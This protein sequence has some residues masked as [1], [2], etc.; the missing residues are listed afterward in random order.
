MRFLKTIK[1]KLIFFIVILVALPNLVITYVSYSNTKNS[2]NVSIEETLLSTKLAYEYAIEGLKSEGLNYAKFF[3]KDSSLKEA[4]SYTQMTD[5]NSPL[6]DILETYFKAL[7]LNNIE[8]TNKQGN[9]LARGHLPAKFGDSKL[10]FP[11][12]KQMLATQTINW[13]YQN[14]KNG[15]TLKF[16]SPI[17][18]D[19]EF[20]GFVGYG[21]YINDAFLQTMKE[22]L[23]ADL[24][25]INKQ[26]V[27]IVATTNKEISDNT[28]SPVLVQESLNKVENTE[29][30]RRINGIPYALLYL[31]V[32]DNDENAFGSMVILKDISH[33]V[34]VV[35]HNLTL[36][37]LI[38]IGAIAV[39][40][41]VSILIATK[42]VAKPLQEF[43]GLFSKL[44]LGNFTK[45]YN[46]KKVNCSEIMKCGKQECPC[47]GKNEVLCWF[48]VGSWAP[49][50]DKKVY[51]PKI[52]SKEYRSCQECKVYQCV[53]D[54]EI[55]TLGAWF[56]KFKAN[57]ADILINI[58]EISTNL[59]DS[60]KSL[61]QV[62]EL[63]NSSTT[64]TSAKSN[65][66]AVA[67]EE[68]NANI[69]SVATAMVETSTNVA[70]VA[71]ATEKM[72]STINEIAQ[73]AEMARGVSAQ[74]VS[75]SENTSKT[76]GKLNHAAQDITS[77]TETIAEISEQI[78]LLAL[79]AT[80]EAA[81]AGEAGKGFA[82][83]AN[84]IKELAKQTAEATKS[85]RERIEGIQ[86]STTSSVTETENVI[87]VINNI[88]EI[89]S[90]IATA[91]EEQSVS[92]QEIASNIAQVSQGISEM[93]ENLAQATS[94]TG[95]ITTDIADVNQASNGMTNSS[96]QVSKNAHNLSKLAIE[97][98]EM[99]N[100]FKL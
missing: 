60:S 72:S 80:I 10:N 47:Y 53:C 26:D 55:S 25:F 48:D 3:T 22:V 44:A 62:S 75:Q 73:S 14:G 34:A 52:L 61:S 71:S 89:V 56:N 68:M 19:E 59:G 21:Y 91:V 66:L 24:I 77:V 32:T 31:P 36:A 54:N 33:E 39:G 69:H 93:N 4:I 64:E 49:E 5:D 96:S 45:S 74:A 7:K 85:I 67:S 16:G 98:G 18:V 78:N 41:I 27:K 9:V 87:K 11:F 81:R 100:R 63:M 99:T 51:C 13:D 65:T 35:N 2:F 30:E 76:M 8:F 82:V 12:T 86:I 84:E 23:Q 79:N 57:F 1:A 6:L 15:I 28:I 29:L 40:V 20:A 17:V 46:T 92:T 97:L 94:V 83:V 42:L 90:T 70:M 95:D 43:T 37:V 38:L 50:F 88:N 58:K